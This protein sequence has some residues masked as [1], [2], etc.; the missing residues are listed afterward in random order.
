MNEVVE[1]RQEAHHTEKMEEIV[2][3]EHNNEPEDEEHFEIYSP[4]EFDPW[5]WRADTNE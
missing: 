4:V 5:I 3:C 2:A 1:P